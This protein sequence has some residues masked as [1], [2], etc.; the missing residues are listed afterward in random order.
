MNFMAIGIILL[1]RFYLINVAF[2]FTQALNFKEEYDPHKKLIEIR[3]SIG[4]NV[5]GAFNGIIKEL[6][7]SLSIAGIKRVFQK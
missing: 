5:Q 4:D 7:N 1:N 3:E 2:I 6:R